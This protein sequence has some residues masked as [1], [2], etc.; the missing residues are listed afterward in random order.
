M[1]ASLEL[2]V[3]D[4]LGINQFRET[5]VLSE[6]LPIGGSFGIAS[7]VAV[8]GSPGANP[9][10]SFDD[11]VVIAH[12]PQPTLGS[13]VELTS[14]DWSVPEGAGSFVATARR[15]GEPIGAVSVDYSVTEG[16]AWVGRDF[17]AQSGTLRWEDGDSSDKEFVVQVLDDGNLEGDETASIVL[18]R[19][20]G[21][22]ELGVPASAPFVIVDDDLAT[23]CVGT[24]QRLCLNEGRFAVEAEWRTASG[25]GGVCQAVPLTTDTGY[26][27]FFQPENVEMVVKVLNACSPAVT[28]EGRYW[29]FAAG[30]TNVETRWTVAD[31]LSGQTRSYTNPRITA[32]R[33]IQD[34]A[35]FATCP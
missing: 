27:W 19:P 17:P 22:V 24:D 23:S 2:I 21:S 14:L 31:T 29:V 4:G 33:P 8:S 18:S 15:Q 10:G 34:V 20:M 35:A 28:A 32:F 13:T 3:Q 11:F 7:H 25:E 1:D 9:A 16:T 5:V 12:P 30:L 26:C 6:A